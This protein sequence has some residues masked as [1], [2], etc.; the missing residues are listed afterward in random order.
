MRKKGKMWSEKSRHQSPNLRKINREVSVNQVCQVSGRIKK[1]QCTD[2]RLPW[3]VFLKPH[4]TL[5]N[6]PRISHSLITGSQYSKKTK[7]RIRSNVWRLWWD[8][9]REPSV[10]RRRTEWNASMNLRSRLF[11]SRLAFRVRGPLP[12][13]RNELSRREP[14]SW[15][16]RAWSVSCC[17][18][19][20]HGMSRALLYSPVQTTRC[21]LQVWN[22]RILRA[23]NKVQ[24]SGNNKKSSG[25]V[26]FHDGE[27]PQKRGCC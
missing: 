13:I 23:G 18:G 26:G 9:L 25:V 14:R 12:W 20:R 11:I 2:W 3:K 17:I 6:H 10:L 19:E 4:S 7:E 21:F 1:I 5:A 27:K 22:A 15:I 16:S 8:F 24:R